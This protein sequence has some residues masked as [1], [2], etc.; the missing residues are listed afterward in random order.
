MNKKRKI[1]LAELACLETPSRAGARRTLEKFARSGARADGPQC[2]AHFESRRVR[3]DRNLFRGRGGSRD[4]RF[5]TAKVD[6][7]RMRLDG[8]LSRLRGR[9]QLDR[10]DKARNFALAQAGEKYRESFVRAGLDPLRSLDPS[11]EVSAVYSP[12]GR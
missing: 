1:S 12:N 8:P 6:F 10:T 9:N 7:V 5:E 11:Q 3:A 4:D 2:R